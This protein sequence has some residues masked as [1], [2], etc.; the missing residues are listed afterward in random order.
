M[1]TA[2]VHTPSHKG[3]F[4]AGVWLVASCAACTPTAQGGPS[5]LATVDD[6]PITSV[7]LAAFRQ[8]LPD[9]LQSRFT[10]ESAVTDLLQTLVDRE[11]M[12]I[13]AEALGYPDEPDVKR[14]LHYSFVESVSRRVLSREI[15]RAATIS[16]REIERAYTDEGWDR[17]VWLAHIV[18]D[19]VDAAR[20]ILLRLR[21]GA[22]F[23]ELAH[24]SSSALDA[25]RGGDMMTFFGRG[26]A[27]PELVRA[28][29]LL[30][31]GEFSDPVVT[32]D[33]VEVLR[34]LA[35]REVP[36]RQVR[37]QLVSDLGRRRFEA[38]YN[39]YVESLERRFEVKYEAAA[40]AVI[41]DAH[42]GGTP[43]PPEAVDLPFV[44]YRDRGVDKEISL[45]YVHRLFTSRGFG[46]GSFAD[47]SDVV[48]AG[49]RWIMADTLFVMAARADGLLEDEAFKAETRMR[50]ARRLSTL[51]RRRQ[52]LKATELAA[53]TS[54]Q[55]RRATAAYLD[56]LRQ[57]YRSRIE[58]H[59]QERAPV[60]SN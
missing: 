55:A 37:A 5:I 33:G 15:G 60:G 36:L 43:L 20:A 56:G 22:D 29:R 1:K 46:G 47:S 16:D 26:S 8:K 39:G 23:A 44:S 10:G 54:P 45:G 57:K 41:V 11:L 9:H 40:F 53:V 7:D 24:D 25:L 4:W 49:R 38:K 51:L 17:M 58:W 59:P 18:V 2:K 30:S 32:A 3:P 14:Q 21:A 48:D 31:T 12:V 34:V 42:K 19:S 28:T 27:R 13:E 6:R 50:Y 52:V 35:V